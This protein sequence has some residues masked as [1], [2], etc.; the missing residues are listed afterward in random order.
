MGEVATSS[1]KMIVPS[2]Q[3]N[4]LLISS[5][6]VLFDSLLQKLGLH[7]LFLGCG[8]SSS[9][10]NNNRNNNNNNSSDNNSNNNNNKTTVIVAKSNSCREQ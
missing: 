10:N 8:N 3:P 5:I 9:N 1:K 4:F 6:Y 2:Y 7:I